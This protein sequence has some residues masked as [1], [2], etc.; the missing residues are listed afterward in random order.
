MPRKP[1]KILKLP[2][3]DDYIKNRLIRFEKE[4]ET[5]GIEYKDLLDLIMMLAD[6][7][8]EVEEEDGDF[9]RAADHLCNAYSSM[10]CFVDKLE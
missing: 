3:T 8:S 9:E 6:F 4:L 2:Y 5:K 10:A 7:M 1:G